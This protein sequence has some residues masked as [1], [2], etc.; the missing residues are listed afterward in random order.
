MNLSKKNKMT[1]TVTTLENILTHLYQR[2]YSAWNEKDPKLKPTEQ[3]LKTYQTISMVV[4]P[5]TRKE[6]EFE[7]KPPNFILDISRR[8]RVLYLPPL[9][10]KAA[11][12]VPLLVPSCKLNRKKSTARLQV[13]LV[14]LDKGPK[15]VG[16]GFRLETP[17][18]TNQNANSTSLAGIHDFHHGQLIRE[19][20][21]RQLDESLRICCPWWL[22]TTQPSFP[23]PAQCPVMLLLCLILTLYGKTFYN[24]F[25]A[26]YEIFDIARYSTKLNSWIN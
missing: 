26:D 14:R 10:N 7:Y 9:Q 21:D 24:Q 11:D 13:M 18:R 25:L 5:I 12:F 1:K 3:A 23:L 20:R 19:F 2:Q 16:M 6:T 8:G 22:P 15:P 17:E 4:P